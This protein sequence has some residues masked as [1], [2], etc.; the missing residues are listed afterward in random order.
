MEQRERPKELIY[1]AIL[2]WMEN[3]NSHEPE[4]DTHLVVND[5]LELLYRYNYVIVDVEAARRG[6]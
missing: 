4:K 1:L 6:Y 3:S 2:P 5:V